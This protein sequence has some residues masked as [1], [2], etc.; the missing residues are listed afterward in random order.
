MKKSRTKWNKMAGTEK[1]YEYTVLARTGRGKVG[2]RVLPGGT[3]R[4]RVEPFGE[5][6]VAKMK[7]YMSRSDG[8]KQPGD[9]DQ[10]RF[11]FI[12]PA[13][14]AK[15]AVQ[16]ALAAIGHGQLVSKTDDVVIQQWIT[17]SETTAS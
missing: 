12:A 7:E 17:M 9:N 5:R 10:F 3:V 16:T 14:K 1:S 4:I 6:F 11:S 13:G 15:E 2:V 8:W